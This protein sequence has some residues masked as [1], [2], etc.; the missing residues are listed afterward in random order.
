MNIRLFKSL[1]IFS[2]LFCSKLFA[3]IP[4]NYYSTATNKTGNTLKSAL[5]DITKT[6]HIKL[7]YTS[8]SFDV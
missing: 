1:L 4:T 5:R 8:T 2:L 3:Q 6:G 7:P